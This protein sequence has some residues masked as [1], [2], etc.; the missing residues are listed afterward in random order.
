MRWTGCGPGSYANSNRYDWQGKEPTFTATNAFRY[1][2]GCRSP[3]T[4]HEIWTICNG[5][6]PPPF[7]G[8]HA[9]DDVLAATE[10]H[11]PAAFKRE[12]DPG[13]GLE[14]G[15]CEVSERRPISI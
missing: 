1:G 4:A 14:L 3:T 9:L 7:V 13:P 12:A 10:Q 8:R 5:Q 6:P 11:V 2:I 15:R